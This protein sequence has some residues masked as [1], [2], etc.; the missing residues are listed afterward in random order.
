MV[1][2][3]WLVAG[4]SLLFVAMGRFSLGRLGTSLM[5][6]ACQVGRYHACPLLLFLFF[7]LLLSLAFVLVVSLVEKLRFGIFRVV[8]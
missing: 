3:G 4:F 2:A 7:L 5:G 1:G 6:L 8:I